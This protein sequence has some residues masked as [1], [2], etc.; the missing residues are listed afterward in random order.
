[1]WLVGL[2]GRHARREIITTSRCR[3]NNSKNTVVIITKWYQ[4]KSDYNPLEKKL[5]WEKVCPE[6]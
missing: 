1:V 5:A 2:R 6:L 4:I 3:V